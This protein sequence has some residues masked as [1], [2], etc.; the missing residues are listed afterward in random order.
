MS[1][2]STKKV[3]TGD[4]ETVFYEGGEQNRETVIFLH[5]GG[6]GATAQSNWKDVLPVFSEQYHVLAPDIQGFGSTDHPEAPP[7]DMLGWMRQRVDQIS[8]LLDELGIDKAHVVG[9]SM[10]GALALNLIMNIP[11][12]F[13]RV[14][15]MGSAGA[16]TEPTPELYRMANFYNDPTPTALENLFKWFVYDEKVLGDKLKVITEER[17]QE[18]MR[19]E[20]RRSYESMFKNPPYMTIPPSALRRME[21]P[22]F[23]IHGRDDRFVPFE[24]SLQFLKHLPNAQLHIFDRCGHWVQAERKDEFVKLVLDFLGGEL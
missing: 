23:L 15:L 17:Y 7:T 4:Y 22:F 8:A 11:E 21:H 16:S 12:R 19:P 9:N 14:V 10:G 24:A 20:V 2:I 13:E 5:G 18:V 1:I 3:Q 6:P